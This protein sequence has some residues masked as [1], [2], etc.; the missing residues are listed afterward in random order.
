MSTMELSLRRPPSALLGLRSPNYHRRLTRDA[1]LTI[2]GCSG[3]FVI[4][5]DDLTNFRLLIDI[6]RLT[7]G[8]ETVSI[9]WA[10]TRD[11]TVLG[12]A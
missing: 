8:S 9:L 5:C 4:T 3:W 7:S 6:R 2:T 11:L 1:S 12:G 10:T